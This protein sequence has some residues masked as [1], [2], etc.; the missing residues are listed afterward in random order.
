MD[1]GRPKVQLPPRPPPSLKANKETVSQPEPEPTGSLVRE[2]REAVSQRLRHIVPKPSLESLRLEAR[3]TAA[4]E[5]ANA[6]KSR[7][8]PNGL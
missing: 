8:G 6:R 2:W 3:V 1:R 4:R 7:L 5:K